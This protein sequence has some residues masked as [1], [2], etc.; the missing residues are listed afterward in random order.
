MAEAKTNVENNTKRIKGSKSQFWLL[1]TNTWKRLPLVI[2]EITR[3]FGSWSISTQRF[4]PVERKQWTVEKFTTPQSSPGHGWH[5]FSASCWLLCGLMGEWWVFTVL[6]W[7]TT[8][9]SVLL[10]AIF[11][12]FT[13]HIWLLLTFLLVAFLCFCPNLYILLQLKQ[14]MS[15][16]EN[17]NGIKKKII[18]FISRICCF[19]V[20]Y[21]FKL[22]IKFWT[23][24]GQNMTFEDLGLLENFH[25]FVIEQ[26]INRLI[27]KIISR[28]IFLCY[29]IIC[30]TFSW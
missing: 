9:L 1:C 8:A 26:T 16:S 13:Y 28:L 11:A 2:K 20:I 4:I 23:V 22:S 5:R 3:I 24:V 12:H 29:I 6:Y 15:Q 30:I 25:Y 10:N 18:L 19:S 14:S 17:L 7:K 27:K 21:D